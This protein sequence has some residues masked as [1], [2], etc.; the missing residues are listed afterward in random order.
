[1][2]LRI[3]LL[4]LAVVAVGCPGDEQ[5]SGP[6][7]ECTRVGQQCRMGGGQLGVCNMNTS[8][9]YHCTSQH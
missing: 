6:V 7:D 3:L 2:I 4:I 8:G 1:V 9:E 5:N